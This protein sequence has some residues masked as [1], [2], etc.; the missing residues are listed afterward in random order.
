[1]VVI[2]AFQ[3]GPVLIAIVATLTEACAI[4]VVDDG[5]GPQY[6][7]VFDSIAAHPRVTLIRHAANR[8]KGA[9]LK[10][11]IAF[12]LAHFTQTFGIVTADADGQHEPDDILAMCRRFEESPDHLILGVRDFRGPVPWRS[13]LGNQA[14]CSILRIV[15][16]QTFQD[17]QTGLR[18][19]PRSLLQHLLNIPATGYEFELEMLI[20]AKHRQVPVSEMPIRTIYRPGN[21]ESHFRPVRDSLRIY[22]VLLRFSFIALL[23]AAIDNVIFWAVL[24]GGASSMQSP[25]MQSQIAARAIAGCFNYLSVRRLAFLSDEPHAVVLPRYLLLLATH[26]LLSYQAIRFLNHHYLLNLF[27][28]KILTESVLFFANFVIQ[29]DVVFVRGST[30]TDWDRYYRLVPLTAHL[31]RRYTLSVLT[32]LLRAQPRVKTIVELG[33]ANSCFLDGILAQIKVEHYHV[34]DQNEYGLDLLRQRPVTLHRAD[35]LHLPELELQAD[36]VFSVGLIEHFDLTGTRKAVQAHFKLLRP[37]GLAILSF[38]T[39]TW[40]YVSARAV[41]E[42]LGLWRFPDER[43][44]HRQEVLRAL[45]GLGEIVF[46]KTLWP[47]VFTQRIIAIRKG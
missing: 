27:W 21:A 3:P 17:T 1:M 12:V 33:G 28:A 2:P 19:I 45:N 20:A 37:G 26:T 46:E 14:T 18:A 29:R 47:L 41:T 43:P 40:L 22:F 9:A 25:M 15:M 10:S 30:V 44:L 38:P 6:S 36:V 13:R 16:G 34:I 4:V 11:G 24:A 42:V 39:P 5:S 7:G 32:K 35:V 8:G 31:T 23:T